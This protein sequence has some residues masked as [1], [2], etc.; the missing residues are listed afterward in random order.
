[1][2][3]Y[4]NQKN[5]FSLV[6]M[7][8]VAAISTVI[9]GALFASFIYSLELISNARARLS[10]LALANEQ[11][12]YFRS[13]PYDDVGTVSGIPSGVIP[14]NGTTTLNDILFYERVLVEYVDDPADGEASADTNGITADY[15]RVKVEYSWNIH[16]ATTTI[17][18][19][20]TIVPRSIETSG[21]GG[22]I[23]IN[24]MDSDSQLLP[25][26][27]VR[28]INTT[29]TTSI[30]VSKNTDSTGSALFSG[31]PANSGYELIVTAVIGGR[32]YSTASTY[33]AD[34]VNVNPVLAPFAVLEADISTIT[35]QIGELSDLDVTAFSGLVTGSFKDLFNS[36]ANVESAFDT[37]VTGG[38]VRLV[39]SGSYAAS[40]TMYL[41]PVTPT[42]ID[43][44]EVAIVAGDRPVS[45][46]YKLQ[47]FT[48]STTKTLIPDVDL[49]GNSAGFSSTRIDMRNL[50]ALA[51]PSIIPGLT[52]ETGNTSV[53]PSV[54]SLALYYQESGVS[55]GAAAFGI[56]GEKI[57]GTNASSSP[58]Y[59]FNTT[60]NTNGSGQYS[61]NNLEFDQYTITTPGSYTIAQACSRHPVVHSAGIDTET[62]LLL[63]ST[64]TNSLRVVVVD[65]SGLSIPGASVTLSRSGFNV[66]IDSS[67]CG[68]SFFSSGVSS[69]NDY[70]VA[71]SSPGYSS[72]TVTGVDIT[73]NSVITV[74]LSGL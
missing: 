52:L 51:Y 49:P 7:I 22:T 30:D 73:G 27:T 17:S 20:S 54:E 21:G 38:S 15:K 23:R 74:T 65:S 67:F 62:R 24:V 70:E 9:F 56:R 39:N 43:S 57:I 11:M 14:Q 34:S 33:V 59:K 71:V 6:E 55:F 36:T 40:G 44:W 3:F 31:A 19:V 2:Q 28:L 37:E 64:P 50:D 8:V 45:T 72:E 42:S 47:F 25:G 60:F 68:Q 4:S 61:F 26:A 63:Q 58:I 18:L 66:S 41:N 16:N 46:D 48:G 69:N 13:L 32:Q 35:V 10:A 29:G 53:T 12:E 1:M 5:G